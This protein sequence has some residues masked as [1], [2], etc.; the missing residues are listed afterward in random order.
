M[1][2]PSTT[3]QVLV[4]WAIRKMQA[5][6]FVP[7]A[8]D[9]KLPQFD[10]ERRLHHPPTI[11]GV[12]PDAFA[13]SPE[14]GSFAFAE[15]KTYDDLNS[16]HTKRQLR[17]YARVSLSSSRNPPCIYIATPRSAAMALDRLLFD[18]GL[19]TA[20]H[21]RRMHIPDCLLYERSTAHA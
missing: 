20:R 13:F 3:H 2:N 17:R 1:A 14:E 9:G 21:I 16:D 10:C 12:R 15:A 4:M 7:V 8:Y 5:D 18:A 6:G 11:G 19:I